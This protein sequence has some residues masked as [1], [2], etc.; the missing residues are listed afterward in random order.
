MRRSLVAAAAASALLL[1]APLPALAGPTAGQA[2][3]RTSL[4]SSQVLMPF[5]LAHAAGQLYV[6]DGATRK[7][8]RVVGQRLVT[9]ATGQANGDVA[10]LDVSANGRFVAFTTT[11]DSH[12]KTTLEIYGPQGRRVTADLSAHERRVNPD[13]RVSYGIDNPSQCVRDA[14][15]KA[16][17]AGPATYRGLVD[18]HPYAVARLG[19]DWVVADAGGNDLLRVSPSGR[20]STLAVLPRQPLRITAAM[21]KSMGLADCVV[22]KVYYF[23]SVPT[24]VEVGRGGW[25]YV[26]TLAGGPEDPSFGARSKVYRV[27]PRTGRAVQIGSGFAGATNLALKGD[28]VYVA[29]FYRG[30]ISVLR[31]GGPRPYV[32]LKNALSLEAAPRGLYAGTSADFGPNGPVGSGSIVHIR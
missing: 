30:R 21:A 16:E 26:T 6:A 32:T 9:V 7:V 17:D 4:V 11:N 2:S 1:T 18:S 25:L 22:G 15:A 5:N 28:K 3:P 20:V 23:E 27:N 8:S 12:S 14:F 19:Q 31:H 13:Q 29:E 10:G 24:D